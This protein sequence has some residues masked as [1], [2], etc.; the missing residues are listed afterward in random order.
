MVVFIQIEFMRLREPLWV[1]IRRNNV[2]SVCL[3]CG[4]SAINVTLMSFPGS[5]YC[6]LS[7]F[8]IRWKSVR[9]TEADSST[10]PFLLP[11]ASYT[12]K[13]RFKEHMAAGERVTSC[14]HCKWG[15]ICCQRA[16]GWVPSS[17]HQHLYF[18]DMRYRCWAA[19]PYADSEQTKW[20]LW[21]EHL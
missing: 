16:E 12:P 7:F 4:Y 18:T 11:P 21:C 19:V 5:V 2:T 15:S 8:H 3:F 9:G 13:S 20:Q 14:T 1:C 6:C 10:G 17:R